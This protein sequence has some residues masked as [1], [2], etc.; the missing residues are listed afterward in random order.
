MSAGDLMEMLMH[1]MTEYGYLVGLT[2][3]L[4]LGVA[5][6]KY[7][8]RTGDHDWVFIYFK[9]AKS[10]KLEKRLVLTG[11]ALLIAWVVLQLVEAVMSEAVK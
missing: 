6:Y 4:L 3:M 8:W 9:F 1:I 2:A 7:A 5:Q 10:D 11:G